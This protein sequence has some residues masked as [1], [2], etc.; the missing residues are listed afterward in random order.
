MIG[1]KESRI[2]AA[3]YQE[4]LKKIRKRP[5]HKRKVLRKG[6]KRASYK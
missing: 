6:K 1:E 2:L 5:R 3:S 4:E